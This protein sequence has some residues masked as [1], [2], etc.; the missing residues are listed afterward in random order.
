MPLNKM[1]Y[2]FAEDFFDFLT[3]EQD[4]S[5]NTAMKYVKNDKHVLT[6]AVSRDWITKSPIAAFVCSYV[7]PE[8]D[9]LND[10]EILAM[11][12]KEMPSKRLEEMRDAYLF[13][14]FTGF[15]YKDASMLSPDH[16]CKFFDGEEWIVKNR[17]KTWCSENVPLLPV[18]RKSLKNTGTTR[19]V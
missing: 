14:C 8:R 16:V 12:Y 17:E 5:S 15:A 6:N 10:K 4:I 1:T 3:L 11:Y 7:H 13:M 18:Q 19:I 9:I 2:S